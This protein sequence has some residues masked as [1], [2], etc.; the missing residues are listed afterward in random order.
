MLDGVPRLSSHLAIEEKNVTIGKT[1]VGTFGLSV[2]LHIQLPGVDRI[3]AEQVVAAAHQSGSG[4]C[5][6]QKAKATVQK[7]YWRNSCVQ[8]RICWKESPKRERC[9]DKLSPHL[10]TIAHY[11]ESF[12]A[13][14]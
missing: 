14:S 7:K 11:R 4:L 12:F 2:A 5:H 10:G 6:T 3:K 9:V 8:R 13:T 1:D